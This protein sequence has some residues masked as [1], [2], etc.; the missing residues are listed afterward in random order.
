MTSEIGGRLYAAVSVNAFEGIDPAMLRRA[1]ASFDGEGT[2]S[3]LERRRRSWIP[4]V[5]FLSG[6]SGSVPEA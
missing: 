3:R 5:V 2:D 6:R 4:D 1:A